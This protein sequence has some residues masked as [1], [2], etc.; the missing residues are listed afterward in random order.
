MFIPRMYLRFFVHVIYQL[1]TALESCDLAIDYTPISIMFWTLFVSVLKVLISVC[2][3]NVLLTYVFCNRL[4]K[5]TQMHSFIVVCRSLSLTQ[6]QWAKIKVPAGPHSLQRLQETV[7]FLV[8]S[9][10]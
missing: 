9:G 10:F 1:Q 5:T 4:L 7:H 6:F 8:S 2:C 3:F